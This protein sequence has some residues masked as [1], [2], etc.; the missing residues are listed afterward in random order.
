MKQR[1]GCPRIAQQINHAFGT[2][3]NKDVVRR[4]LAQHFTLNSRGDGPSWLTFIGHLKDSLWSADLFRC[5]SIGL[6]TH[7]VMVVMDQYTRRIIGF[8]VQAGAV[9]GVALC[10]IFYN[11]ISCK[12]SPTYLSTE[13]DPLFR[14]HRW[15]A[16]LRILD[17]QE[18]KTIPHVPLSH[19]FVERIIGTIRREILDHMLFWNL[20]DL[21]RKLS[22]FQQYYNEHSV[23]SSLDGVTPIRKSRNISATIANLQNY[24]WKSHCRG[25][26]ELPTAA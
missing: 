22:E 19:P 17:I 13:N 21:E 11:A 4:V 23:H 10:R 5:E 1:F 9:D 24:Q 16:N 6:R 14:F 25:L 15:Q 20:S 3:I 2:D 8:G 26:F 7:W 18:I 12:G